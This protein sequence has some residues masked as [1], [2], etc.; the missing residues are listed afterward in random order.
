MRTIKTLGIATAVALA[1]IA[2]VGAGA[3]S[4]NNFKAG[5]EPET[6]NGSLSGATHNLTMGGASVFNCSEA[7]FSGETKAKTLSSVTVSPTLGG[8]KHQSA[9]PRSWTM[10]GCKFRFN[11]GPGPGLT[12]TMDITGCEKP[13]RY[14]NEYFSCV[15]EIGN[16]NG[17]GPVYYENIS[18]GGVPAL[19]VQANG[20]GITYTRSQSTCGDGSEGTFSNGTYSGEWIVKGASIPGGAAVAAEIQAA[21]VSYPRFAAE[22]GP[23]TLSGKYESKLGRWMFDLADNGKVYCFNPSFSGTAALVPTEAVT[24]TPSFHECSFESKDGKEYYS[25]SDESLTAGGCS[26]QLPAKGGFNIVGATCAAN[27]IKVTVPGC[28]FKVGPQSSAVGPTYK[29]QGTGTSRTVRLELSPQ[30]NTY[31]AEGA[32]CAKTGTL[33]TGS[34]KVAQAVLSAKT[35]GGAAQGFWIE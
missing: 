1:L 27:P 3:A 17:L 26:Y 9:A 13:M 20:S 15:S 35:S 16:Q 32:G 30:K 24:I 23:A 33:S 14:E 11:A 28:V 10:N 22:E 12:G 21:T 2:V 29:N 5:V 4:A 31:T 18:V 6:W 25:I 34:V 8:C 7:A 19:K